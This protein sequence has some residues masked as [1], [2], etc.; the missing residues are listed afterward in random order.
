MSTY[1]VSSAHQ[2]LARIS[3]IFQSPEFNE[4]SEEEKEKIAT[5]FLIDIRAIIKQ[6]AFLNREERIKRVEYL[7]KL[8]KQ[9]SI[10]PTLKRLAGEPN[11]SK[12]LIFKIKNLWGCHLQH[13]F[14]ELDD[15]TDLTLKKGLKLVKSCFVYAATQEKKEDRKPL[16]D[17]GVSLLNQLLQRENR[18]FLAPLPVVKKI[19]FLSETFLSDEANPLLIHLK[20]V[21]EDNKKTSQLCHTLVLRATSHF[22]DC[23]L[24]NL[25]RKEESPYELDYKDFKSFYDLA[26][27]G[28]TELA[29][30][31]FQETTQLLSF[32][33]RI[34]SKRKL[35]KLCIE[36]IN[37]SQNFFTLY[38]CRNLIGV[39]FKNS[40][41]KQILQFL[42]ENKVIFQ[43]IGEI[44][45]TAF[46]SLAEL[47]FKKLNEFF[48]K[49][50]HLKLKFD[51]GL[52]HSIWNSLI[53][54]IFNFRDF[55][56]EFCSQMEST[57][58]LL[59][60]AFS[61]F[62]K[63]LFSETSFHLKALKYLSHSSL[64][65]IGETFGENVLSLDFEGSILKDLEM[66][67]VLPLF[68]NLKV[69]TLAKCPS[70]GAESIGA[71]KD[72]LRQ[73][74]KLSFE[75]PG[76][77]KLSDE[78]LISI[79]E[80]NPSIV[81]LNLNWQTDIT[82]S[83]LFKIANTLPNLISLD[84]RHLAR[85]NLDAI[86]EVALNCKSLTQILM[87]F[88]APT[89]VT[90]KNEVAK[91]ENYLKII[92][93]Q[94]KLK[95]LSFAG[96][97]NKCYQFSTTLLQEIS[98]ARKDCLDMEIFP[99]YLGKTEK[100]RRIRALQCPKIIFKSSAQLLGKY[101]I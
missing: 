95:R 10:S 24:C 20:V 86:L 5:P 15:G 101:K 82:S 73:L 54:K 13:L 46:S 77:Y 21:E 47:E 66:K 30:K 62:D 25:F 48:P 55:S 58:G 16:F 72:N 60:E 87:D 64:M 39:A 88:C 49:A 59:R 14:N 19:S 3:S 35:Q 98:E 96:I 70:I 36:K 97:L 6:S 38:F 76:S 99:D 83:S 100:E 91:F 61:D 69:L 31:N 89:N 94:R 32:L 23:V 67:E 65:F 18:F 71:I 93:K 12:S 27:H 50:V 40:D 8:F 42:S 84:I 11:H 29:K 41:P 53:T 57:L 63:S 22:F 33:F 51:A 90:S 1:S 79:I 80:T 52:I 37:A 45:I 2:S 4:V 92:A 9:I 43:E 7:E 26:L 68:K 78:D 85:V 81:E 17:K 74:Q 75:A 56:I 28:K 44:D 34:G